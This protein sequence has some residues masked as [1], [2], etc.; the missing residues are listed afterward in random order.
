MQPLWYVDSPNISLQENETHSEYH[1]CAWIAW[2]NNK[3]VTN[4][5][6]DNTALSKKLV[7]NFEPRPDVESFFPNVK[8]IGLRGICS[9]EEVKNLENILITFDYENQVFEV[10][11]PTTLKA[12]GSFLDKTNKFSKLT[13]FLKCPKST[14]GNLTKD[15]DF[16]YC[17]ESD[18]SYQIHAGLLDFTSK[19]ISRDI[20]E[21]GSSRQSANYYDP[22]SMNFIHKHNNG[23]VLDYGSGVRNRY[24]DHVINYEICLLYTSPSPR[25]RQKSRMP[26]SA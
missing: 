21:L 23:L 26:S 22:D 5:K 4:I 20:E 14:T 10:Y 25:D 17:K 15:K 18:Q 16:F 24:F 12:E 13:P 2:P 11:F 19:Q 8:A 1:L 3:N 9:L 6:I 7:L